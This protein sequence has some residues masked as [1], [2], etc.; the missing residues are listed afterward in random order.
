M[1]GG[2]LRFLTAGESHGRGLVVI[3][4]GLPA[5]VPVS[6][7]T[8]AGELARRRHGYGRGGRQRFEADAFEIQ[9]G[10]RHGR[11]IGAPVAITIPITPSTQLIADRI[12]LPT[13]EIAIGDP[14]VR[15]IRFKGD[16]GG[17]RIGLDV[18]VGRTCLKNR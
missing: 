1:I 15:V 11:T 5:G 14:S 3:V 16:S 4:E 13:T 7:D 12:A 9:A 8:I 18:R 10:V 6:A 2:V 17:T